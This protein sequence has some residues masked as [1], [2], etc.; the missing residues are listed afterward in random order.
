MRPEGRGTGPALGREKRLVLNGPLT[1]PSVKPPAPAEV[2]DRKRPDPPPVLLNGVAG[3][4]ILQVVQVGRGRPPPCLPKV[5]PPVPPARLCP[6]RP[7]D[8]AV[9]PDE[10]CRQVPPRPGV[11]TARLCHRRRV[12]VALVLVPPLPDLRQEVRLLQAAH[13]VRLPDPCPA[14][15]V[16]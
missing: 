7:C 3:D 5:R 4:E 13:T 11:D 10:V 16:A 1:P 6:E 15:A 12:I 9:V 2:S 8:V 14:K